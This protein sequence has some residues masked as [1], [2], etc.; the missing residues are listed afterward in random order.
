MAE[1]GL[2]AQV[3]RA[4]WPALPSRLLLVIGF[5]LRSRHAKAAVVT[6]GIGRPAFVLAQPCGQKTRGLQHALGVGPLGHLLWVRVQEPK[7]DCSEAD[8]SLGPAMPT[9]AS[10]QKPEDSK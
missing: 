3:R 5:A 1:P 7:G 8:R 9:C 2:A 10:I 6:G 4:L